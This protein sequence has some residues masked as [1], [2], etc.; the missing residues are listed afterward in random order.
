MKKWIILLFLGLFIFGI[1]F[2]F[3]KKEKGGDLVIEYNLD[4]CIANS[5]PESKYMLCCGKDKN[6][7]S[8]MGK[9]I[10]NGDIVALSVNITDDYEKNMLEYP[11]ECYYTD[12]EPDKESS[13][14]KIVID[15]KNFYASCENPY[16]FFSNRKQLYTLFIGKVEKSPFLFRI[17]LA[18]EGVDEDNL[19]Q[20]MNSCIEVFFI[21]R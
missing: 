19:A 10:S 9:D 20:N 7:D 5:N 2:L 17:L 8:C 11:V 15:N 1:W 12:I 16:N 4:N 14:K 3:I 13:V 6:L 18:P 21:E